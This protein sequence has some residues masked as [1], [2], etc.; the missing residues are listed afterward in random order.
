MVIRNFERF[1]DSLRPRA[2]HVVLVEREDGRVLVASTF[3]PRER[4]VLLR[5]AGKLGRAW[6]II[7]SPHAEE[8]VA[9]LRAA[10]ADVELDAFGAWFALPYCVASL[11]V[12]ALDPRFERVALAWSRTAPRPALRVVAHG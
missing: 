6:S 9:A 1:L 2:A 4:V 7:D 5:A 8:I 10:V 12:R 3:F 11:R